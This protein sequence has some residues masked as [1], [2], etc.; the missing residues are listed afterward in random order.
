MVTRDEAWALLQE[1]GQS[2]ALFRHATAVEACMRAY[3]RQLG[4]DED[5]WGI[6]GMLHDFDW[7]ACPTPEEH[8]QFGADI[9]KARGYPDSIVKA[10]LSHGNHTGVPR[11]TM[12]EKALFSL[13][14]LSGFVTAVALVRPTKSLGDTDVRSVRKKMKDKAFAK[15]VSREDIAQGAEELGVDL[16]E[17]I[18]FVID[19]LKPVAGTLGLAAG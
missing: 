5:L 6:T 15:S 19:A 17:H 18:T 10:V 11:E 9:L 3:A 13:D 8:P 2:D 1:F 16:D 7:D 14:E 12:M 4:E